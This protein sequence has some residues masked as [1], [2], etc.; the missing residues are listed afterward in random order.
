MQI[1]RR[2]VFLLFS[3]VIVLVVLLSKIVYDKDTLS[4]LP[5]ADDRSKTLADMAALCVGSVGENVIIRRGIVFNAKNN[6]LLASYCHGQI[7][8]MSSDLCRMGKYGALVNYSQIDPTKT[9]E[10]D[11]CIIEF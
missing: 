3:L 11:V 4:T 8:S 10:S 6:Q 5:S 7:N 2:F 9:S 1:K